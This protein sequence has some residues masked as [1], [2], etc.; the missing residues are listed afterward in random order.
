MFPL[1]HGWTDVQRSEG[2]TCTCPPG[3]VACASVPHQFQNLA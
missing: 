1:I 2:V 3:S